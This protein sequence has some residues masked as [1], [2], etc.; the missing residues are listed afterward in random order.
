V[1]AVRGLSSLPQPAMWGGW[2]LSDALRLV[3]AAGVLSLAGDL[4]MG[5]PLEHGL[6]T[7]MLAVRL[8]QSMGLPTD[9]QVSVFYT[10]LLNSAGCTADSEVDARFFGDELAARPPMM[11]AFSGSRLGLMI[12]TMR[13]AHRGSPPLMRAAMMARSAV[14]GVAEFRAWARAHCDVA[15]LLGARMGLT[16][17]TQQALRHL[18]ERW[19]GKGMPGDIRGEQLPLAVR[20]MHVAQDADMAWHNGGAELADRVLAQRAGSGLDPHAVAAFRKLGGQVYAGLDAPSIWDEVMLGEP[21]PQPLVSENRMDACLSA[22]A[23][24]A[25]LKSMWTIG[26]SRGVGDLAGHAGVLAGLNAA[27]VRLLR[28][29]ALVHDIGRVTVPFSVWAKPG[30][31]TRGEREQVRLHAYHSERVLDV[32]DGLRPLARL[33]GSHGERCDGSGYHR[34]SRAADLPLT[35]RLLA[36]AD[37]YQAMREH[38]AHRPAL[39]PEAAASEL[40][41]EAEVGRLAP[42]A[43]NAVLAAAGQPGRPVSRPAGLSGRECEV[44]ALLARGM[45][46]KQIARQ[47]GISPKTCDHHIQSVYAKVGVSTRAGATLFALEHGLTTLS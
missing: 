23:D 28:R 14:G 44:L 31:L 12:A 7:A 33:A 25:D 40:S 37:C 43:V 30:P 2:A 17:Q 18:Y 42:E 19:D 41:R 9:D 1:W 36:A 27:D 32:A 38:R 16:A 20:L 13:V 22:V 3:E 35:A 10:G 8:A 21:G 6:R 39:P 47:L 4:A 5:Q 29:A 15:R 11:A 45:A 26:H 24:F 34:G 46:T